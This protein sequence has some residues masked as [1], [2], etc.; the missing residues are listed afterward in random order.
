MDM[1]Y[2]KIS[3]PLGISQVQHLINIMHVE[4][5]MEH[6]KVSP[7]TLGYE[8][9]FSCRRDKLILNVGMGEGTNN[10]V[11][12]NALWLLFAPNS[13]LGEKIKGAYMPSWVLLSMTTV[14]ERVRKRTTKL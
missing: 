14:E 8:A 5:L 1:E 6:A 9:Y 13:S 12:L 10:W 11:E 2:W 7:K 4:I 3:N